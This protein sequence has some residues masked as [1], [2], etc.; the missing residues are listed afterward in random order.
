M[1]KLKVPG[2]SQV[3]K[4]EDGTGREGETAACWREERKK[5]RRRRGGVLPAFLLPW[6]TEVF[7][8]ICP[9]LSLSHPP[10]SPAARHNTRHFCPRRLDNVSF[11]RLLFRRVIGKWKSN[12]IRSRFAAAVPPLLWSTRRKVCAVSQHWLV[13]INSNADLHI[14]SQ[15]QG[16]L[17]IDVPAAPQPE[18]TFSFGVQTA[19][20]RFQISPPKFFVSLTSVFFLVFFF[21]CFLCRFWSRMV[22]YFGLGCSWEQGKRAHLWA[23]WLHRGH[24]PVLQ[25]P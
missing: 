10:A 15:Q 11:L 7:V 14:H 4:P 13:L 3:E 19:Q 9:S 17:M 18:N 20:G 21:F 23:T 6:R 1:Q 24:Q 8:S 5:G 25:G 22:S 2:D 16:W 12:D